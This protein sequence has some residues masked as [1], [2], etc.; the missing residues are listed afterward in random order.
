MTR[1]PPRAPNKEDLRKM[2]VAQLNAYIHDL[3]QELEWRRGP[4]HKAVSK[5]LE[6]AVKVRD[7]QLGNEAARDV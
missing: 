2:T 4:A 5:R 7:V 3:R 1:A 6:V